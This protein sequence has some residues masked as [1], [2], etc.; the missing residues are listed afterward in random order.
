MNTKL[1]DFKKFIKGKRIAVIG[2]GI[3]NRP[4]I[5]Y[6]FSLGAKITAF[7]KLDKDDEVLSKTIQDMKNEGIEIE[8]SVG[9]GYLDALNSSSFDMIFK[10]PKMRA[11]TP[12]FVEAVKKGSILTTEMELFMALCP[13]KIFAITGS[14]GKTTTTTLV[15]EMLKASGKTVYVGGNIG[16]PLL[17]RIDDIVATDYVVLELSSFQLLTMK[18]S[19][20][21]AVVTNVTPNHL[22]FHTSYEE[23]IDTKTNIFKN[24]SALG[25]VVL[26][27]KCDITRNMSSLARGQ[28]CFF[29][30][31]KADCD[32]N[33]E[34]IPI[35]YVDNHILTVEAEGVKTPIIDERDIKIFGQHN[36]QNYLTAILA[37]LSY[38]SVDDIVNVAKN[39]GGVEHRIEFIRE[40]DGVKYYNSSIDTSPNR[41]IN[42][43]NALADRNLKGVLIA[44]GADKNCDYT[45]L[46]DAILKVCDR[47]LL[48]GSN[49][50]L[51]KAIISKEANGRSYEIAELND[52]PECLQKA[53]ELAKEGEIVILSPTGTS[54][55]HFR[56]F[57][58][59]GNLFKKLV[60]EL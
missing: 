18:Q 53:R 52:Y 42:T 57:E 40:L 28:Q 59:R 43:M 12:Q 55:D 19:A 48:Y 9:E 1:N 58:T 11:E 16:T 39:F 20:D 33:S 21:V 35:A 10:T 31:D 13:Y 3:S 30:L 54:Y 24:Q 50:E 8:W 17:S 22:D 44:G 29:A 56:H 45:G 5:R 6:M 36:V 34:L 26:N 27:G 47:I 60:N 46:G 7:D 2:V 32:M 49:A 4:L 15:S 41:T 14:D 37:C 38:V 25:R 23:Y 51:V